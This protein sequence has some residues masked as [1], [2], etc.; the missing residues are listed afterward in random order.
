M[1]SPQFC[2]TDVPLWD[3]LLQ[4][5]APMMTHICDGIFASMLNTRTYLVFMNSPRNGKFNS[6]NCLDAPPPKFCGP[7]DLYIGD[8]HQMWPC[9]GKSLRF[10]SGPFHFFF[11]TNI[12]PGRGSNQR[13]S[14]WDSRHC[15]SHLTI[16][17]LRCYDITQIDVLF[18]YFSYISWWCV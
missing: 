18:I 8:S 13:G 11:G 1:D 5:F 17:P 16:R 14:A 4:V 3:F 2:H 15:F 7:L 10:L 12:S 9:L 6:M